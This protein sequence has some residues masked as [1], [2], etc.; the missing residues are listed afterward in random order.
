[1][2]TRI[3]QL[4]IAVSPASLPVPTGGGGG[5]DGFSALGQGFAS[6][7]A[8][9]GKSEEKRAAL[10]GAERGAEAAITFELAEPPPLRKG[11]SAEDQAFDRALM[12]GYAKR[13]ELSTRQNI[14]RIAAAN[15]R[16]AGAYAGAVQQWAQGM[17]KNM[18]SAV[19]PGFD[20]AVQQLS[21]PHA[22]AIAS[23]QR[24]MAVEADKE[25]LGALSGQVLADFRSYGKILAS[26]TSPDQAATSLNAAR[27]SMDSVINSISGSVAAGTRDSRT[28]AAQLLNFQ[29][30]MNASIV[31]GMFDG[32]PD[33]AAFQDAFLRGTLRTPGVEIVRDNAG[34]FTVSATRDFDPTTR[35]TMDQSTKMRAYMNSAVDNIYQTRDRNRTEVNRIGE[36]S[37]QVQ[38]ANVFRTRDQAAYDALLKNP[39]AKASDLEKAA[40]YMAQGD[41]QTDFNTARQIERAI[42]QGHEFT[43]AQ[44]AGARLSMADRNRLQDLQAAQSDY[45]KA[46]V[47]RDARDEIRLTV[48]GVAQQMIAINGDVKNTATRRQELAAKFEASLVREVNNRR[49]EAIAAGRGFGLARSPKGEVE[50]SYG[51]GAPISFDPYTWVQKRIERVNQRIAPVAA[52]QKSIADKIAANNAIAAPLSQRSDAA[53]RARLKAIREENVTLKAQQQSADAFL[54]A[55]FEELN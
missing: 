29:T 37:V 55:L 31:Q 47:F 15:P 2:A 42:H 48:G 46:P 25:V 3:T 34:K 40:T 38:L 10:A 36:E 50:W 4:G 7:G 53:S 45:Q 21:A 39:S 49:Q 33:K 5:V 44:L 6:L 13:V 17:K 28:A 8:L 54:D 26:A 51:E 16:D 32:A 24:K 27:A 19:Q 1:M 23:D 22:T 41:V 9:L 18:P 20:L 11:T 30:D 52:E 14:A 35:L 43:P 12:D